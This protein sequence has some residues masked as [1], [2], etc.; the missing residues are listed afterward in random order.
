MSESPIVHVSL[1]NESGMYIDS[2]PYVIEHRLK[3]HKQ[4]KN[5]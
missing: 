5:V 4:L 1:W 2:F 3:D